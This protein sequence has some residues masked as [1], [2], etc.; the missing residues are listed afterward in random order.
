MK[1]R[2]L[3][4]F[5]LL[6]S[7]AACEPTLA[8]RGSVLDPDVLNQIRPG[9]TTRE[10]VVS[11]LGSPTTISTF[12]EN[13]WYYIGR[14]TQQYS[15]LSPEVLSQQAVEIQFNETG[16]VVAVRDLDLSQAAEAEPVDRTTP[17][18]GRENSFLREILGDLGR[19]RPNLGTK[20]R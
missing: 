11:K 8:S 5:P 14:Q 15:F 6:L 4:L 2:L 12:D 1:K 20:G 10:E 16:T 3:L 13:V 7:L 19:P 9:Q 18:F 17:T